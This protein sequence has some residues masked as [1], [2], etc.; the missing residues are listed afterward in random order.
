M[1][2]GIFLPAL[3]AFL[4][5]TLLAEST[6]TFAY[7]PGAGIAGTPH[8]FSTVNGRTAL[9]WKDSNGNSTTYNT[10]TPWIDPATGQQGTTTLSVGQCSTCHTQQQSESGTLAWNYTLRPTQYQWNDART[11]AGTSYPTFQ[12]DTYKG[13]SS[14]CLSCHDGLVSPIDGWYGT[15]SYAPGYAVSAGGN[16]SET[17]PIA[18]PYP[19]NGAPSTYNYVRSGAYLAPTEWVADP[20]AANGI[21]LFNDDGT[22][23]IVTGVAAGRTGIECS[24]CHDV[25]NGSRA[26]DQMFVAGLLGGSDSRPGGYICAQCHLK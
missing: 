23:N 8:D 11:T 16:L 5:A 25:H 12:G 6:T 22:G 18:M 3:G 24:S 21:R 2:L 17:H 7:T 15:A 1:S 9:L 10:G 20:M 26:K 13:P 19:I 14:K 4:A